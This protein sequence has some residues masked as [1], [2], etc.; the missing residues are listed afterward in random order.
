[1]IS[2]GIVLV[3]TLIMLS[4]LFSSKV[5][6]S[7]EWRAT[8][9]P[10]ASIIGS[11]FLVSAP[12][13][14]LSTGKLAP[15]AMLVIVMLAYGIGCSIRYNIMNFEPL[16]D[17]GE[18]KLSKTIFWESLSAPVLGLAYIISVAFYLKLLS[19]FALRGF[20]LSSVFI[21]NSLTTCLLLF[22]G[23]TGKV[24]GLSMLE[25]LETYS[26]NTKLAIIVA[27]IVGH[28]VFNFSLMANGE[29]TLLVYPHEGPAVVIRKLLG[30]LII[31]QGFETSRYMGHAYNR[32]TRV[33]TMRYAQVISG[34]IY[35]I[36]ISSTLTAFNNIHT[37][38]ETTVIDVCR[39]I[40]PVLPWLLIIAALMSQFSAAVADT[41]GSGGLL[42][43]A[44][45][46]KVS[47]NGSY[48]MITLIGVM[49]TWATDIYAIITIASKAFAV[50]YAIQIAVTIS[51]LRLEARTIGRLANMIGFAIL[52]ILMVLVVLFGISIE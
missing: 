6:L 28:I 48:L 1:M 34:V 40:A 17:S 14:I 5:R 2:N 38:G 51:L 15:I 31:I 9:T 47:V 27:L 13:L 52:F 3:T 36:F 44:S 45:R 4:V 19:A 23:I 37:L 32:P 24:R 26:V 10:L 42:A 12:L 16:I 43:E 30:V 18:N 25:S 33:K 49:L 20:S 22:I 46:Q 35:V 41:I 29:W 11:G 7:P 8:V 39:T 21:E 50:Y